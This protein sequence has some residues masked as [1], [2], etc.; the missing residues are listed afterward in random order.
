M[1]ECRNLLFCRGKNTINELEEPNKS[2]ADRV[3]L[4][5]PPVPT[6]ETRSLPFCSLIQ[7]KNDIDDDMVLF[8]YD[9][10]VPFQWKYLQNI[11]KSFSFLKRY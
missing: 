3:K 4:L 9:T 8:G 11:G 2:L 10:D 5:R 1:A 6:H 7:V